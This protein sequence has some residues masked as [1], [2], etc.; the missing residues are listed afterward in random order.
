M[1]KLKGRRLKAYVN[2]RSH[3]NYGIQRQQVQSQAESLI[4]ISNMESACIAQ[5]YLFI[6]SYNPSVHLV[7]AYINMNKFLFFF[8]FQ[9]CSKATIT[10]SEIII[11]KQVK[12]TYVM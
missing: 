2:K 7:F 6:D 1:S 11:C 4:R 9:T 10:L 8:F 5:L 12:P 3:C